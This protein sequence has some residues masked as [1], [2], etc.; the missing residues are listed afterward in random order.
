MRDFGSTFTR[1]PA[2][3]PNNKHH[4]DIEKHLADPHF[5]PHSLGIPRAVHLDRLFSQ[6]EVADFL[7]FHPY[8]KPQDQI[9]FHTTCCNRPSRQHLP[10][11]QTL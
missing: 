9:T 7:A 11:S 3:D 1:A 5:G 10:L 4:D 6:K 2:H 8:N